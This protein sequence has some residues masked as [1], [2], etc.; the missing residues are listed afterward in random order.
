MAFGTAAALTRAAR[1][2]FYVRA[3]VHPEFAASIEKPNREAR[4]DL[5]RVFGRVFGCAESVGEP[6]S[7]I[8]HDTL[9]RLTLSIIDGLMGVILLSPFEDPGVHEATVDAVVRLVTEPVRRAREG[10]RPRR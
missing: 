8:D 5:G 3:V 4:G 10:S 6:R 9:V 7:G 2:V 1:A